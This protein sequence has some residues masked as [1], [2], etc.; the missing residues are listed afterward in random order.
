MALQNSIRLKS[1]KSVV[2]VG[3]TSDNGVLILDRVCANRC[4][5]QPTGR[6]LGGFDNK[7]GMLAYMFGQTFLF[8]DV[9]FAQFN[10]TR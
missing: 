5:K 1:K 8:F 6:G 2:P 4:S 7:I 3:T 10:L 9:T